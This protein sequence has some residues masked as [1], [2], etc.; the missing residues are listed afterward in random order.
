ML[1]VK[2]YNQTGEE[3]KKLELPEGIFAVPTKSAVIK[4]AVDAQS[5]NSRQN[6]AHTKGRSEVRGGGRKPW[7]QKGTGRARHGSIRSPLWRGGG[8]TF[9]PTKLRNFFKKINSKVKRQALQM[10]LTNKLVTEHLI[11]VDKIDL[12]DGKTK[13]LNNVLVKLVGENKKLVLA[14]A[15]KDEAIVQASSNLKNIKT[16]PADSLNV[17]ELLRYPYLVV[18]EPAVDKIIKL[19]K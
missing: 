3:V 11:V 17:L 9:G 12:K 2:V 16:L 15:K 8:V 10:V 14:L 4:E 6:F 19:Y 5:A 18:T 1:E 7:R 13:D